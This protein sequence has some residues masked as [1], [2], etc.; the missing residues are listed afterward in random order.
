MLQVLWSNG[1]KSWVKESSLPKKVS[2]ILKLGNGFS[3]MKVE[4][5]GRR[6]YEL[7]VNEKRYD[8]KDDVVV[9]R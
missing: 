8:V 2:E 4:E 9:K 7:R 3:Q 1:Q 5:F 6:H